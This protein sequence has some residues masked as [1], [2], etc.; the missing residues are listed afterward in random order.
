[1]A[2]KRWS[3]KPARAKRGSLVTLDH[4]NYMIWTMAKLREELMDII[5]HPNLVRISLTTS[6]RE[7]KKKKGVESQ[8]D[9]EGEKAEM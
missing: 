1:M 6:A 4:S 3:H 9:A 2:P 8:H 5:V 7:H